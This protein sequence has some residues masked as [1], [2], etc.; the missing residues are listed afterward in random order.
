MLPSVSKFP[1]S[2]AKGTGMINIEMAKDIGFLSGGENGSKFKLANDDESKIIF[3]FSNGL[4]VINYNAF[5][6]ALWN[7][8]A[9]S[10][11]SQILDT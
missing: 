5:I 2:T 9:I 1:D 7:S 6:K 3:A 11:D 8:P 4:S 10:F